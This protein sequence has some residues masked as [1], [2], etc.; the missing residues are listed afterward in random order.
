[1][2][3]R[4]EMMANEPQRSEGMRMLADLAAKY[5]HQHGLEPRKISWDLVTDDELLLVVE[6][7]SQSVTIPF[8]VDEI[9][10]FPGGAETGYSRKKIRD[11]FASLSM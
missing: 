7:E 4:E 1:M 10:D 2:A 3:T 6:T 8:S 11:K 5:A 9:E